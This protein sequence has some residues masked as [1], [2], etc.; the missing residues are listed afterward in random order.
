MRFASALTAPTL[1][2]QHVYFGFRQ[3]WME[4]NI[5]SADES[6]HLMLLLQIAEWEA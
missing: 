5:A 6:R 3:V 2:V 1:R 4:S